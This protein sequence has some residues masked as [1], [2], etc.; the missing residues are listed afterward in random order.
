[1]LHL[2]GEKGQKV[3]VQAG[4][5]LIIPAGVGHKNLGDKDNFGVVGAYPDGRDY[6]IKRGD[7]GDRPQV[8][9]NIAAVPMPSLD[10]IYGKG[11][12]LTILWK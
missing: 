8:I 11:K 7:A 2:G 3:N 10:P 12:G 5:I 9:Q 4:D 6:D 1:M